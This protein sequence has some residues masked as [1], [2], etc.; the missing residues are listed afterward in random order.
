MYTLKIEPKMYFIHV[1]MN[2]LRRTEQEA[3]D[4][5]ILLTKRPK[6]LRT[7]ICICSQEL[8]FTD[9]F[10]CIYMAKE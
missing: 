6:I 4:I 5:N 7:T 9:N 3:I 10:C 8:Y 1:I 2:I